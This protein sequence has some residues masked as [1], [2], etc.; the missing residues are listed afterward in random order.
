MRGAAHWS[1]LRLRERVI[2]CN[3]VLQLAVS[4]ARQTLDPAMR[5]PP[6]HGTVAGGF[7]DASISRR[8]G[9]L[10]KSPV[11]KPPSFPS[12]SRG[13]LNPRAQLL[14]RAALALRA[15]RF[16]EAEQLAA[17]VLRANRTDTAAA[18]MLARA[19]LAQNRGEEAIAPLEK[20]ARRTG[21]PDIEILL[22]AALGSAGRREEAIEQL[23]P[24]TARRPPF[25]PAFQALAG[26]P[27][28][29]G[30]VDQAIAGVESGLAVVPA[31]I[32]LRLD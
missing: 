23:R 32:H 22:R 24:T 15:R 12:I 10:D 17:E 19:L 29:A 9:H 6:L 20:A 7:F 5:W 11:P 31:A 14:E 28:K 1:H 13:Q 18:S 3:T 16:A 25:L 26:Q 2:L 27:P 8:D 21:D 30:R 4:L